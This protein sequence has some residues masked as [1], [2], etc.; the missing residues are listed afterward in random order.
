[1]LLPKSRYGMTLRFLLGTHEMEL[2]PVTER[3]IA[4]GPRTV[5][6]GGAGQGYYAVGLALR[7]PN[8]RVIAFEKATQRQWD[9]AVAAETNGVGDRVVIR[10]TCDADAL[11]DCLAS[12]RPPVLV[13]ADMEGAESRVFAGEMAARLS[14]ATVLI[15]TH[16]EMVPGITDRLLEQF[17]AT[18]RVE[19][20]APRDRTGDDL[21]LHVSSARWRLFSPLL[22]WLV[23]EY[24]PSRQ[25]WLLFTPRVG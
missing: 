24:R 9:I 22:V 17:A 12:A 1:M 21:P 6:N 18:H 8:T 5:I 23:K 3:L 11:R 4:A 14:Q 2:H 13:L 16:D 20:Y 25:R 10:G 7:C 19:I 15:E